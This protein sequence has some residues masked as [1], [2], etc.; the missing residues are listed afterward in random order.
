MPGRFRCT[1]VGCAA[2]G[3]VVDGIRCL[4]TPILSNDLAAVYCSCVS[5]ALIV[6]YIASP[7]L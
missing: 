3:G 5:I 1:F 2:T 4:R 6:T 7:L